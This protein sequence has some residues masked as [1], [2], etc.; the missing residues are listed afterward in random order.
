M[1]EWYIVHTYSGYENKVKENLLRRCESL[2]LQ[3]KITQIVILTE[4]VSEIRGGKKKIMTRK[5]FPGYVLVEM[6]M[7]E[8]SWYA[9]RHT[10]GVFGFVG[11]KN[12][13]TPLTPGETEGIFTQIKEGKGKVRPKV[14][15]EP[16]ESVRVI[17][18]PFINFVGVVRDMDPKREKL[19]VMVNV[20]GRSVPI[21]LEFCQVE[22]L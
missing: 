19:H 22:A 5:V 2:G 3:D 6:E 13:P 16:N 21:E 9:V 7:N 12:K 10:P 17:D 18:G 11:E 8:D 4:E 15:F 1:K 14:T 20:L